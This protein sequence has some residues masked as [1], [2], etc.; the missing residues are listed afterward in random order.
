MVTEPGIY[1]QENDNGD[2]NPSI[3]WGTAKAV[4]RGK[5]IARTALSKKIRPQTFSNLQRK[6]KKK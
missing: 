5:I 2:A 1:L 4:L 6:K 3:L